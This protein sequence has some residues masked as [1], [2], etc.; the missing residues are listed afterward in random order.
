MMEVSTGRLDKILKYFNE[1]LYIGE[2]D[3]AIKSVD[4]QQ[5]LHGAVDQLAKD[6]GSD[7]FELHEKISVGNTVYVGPADLL[8][9]M[10]FNLLHNSVVHRGTHLAKVDIWVEI[11]VK[12]HHVHIMVK[13]N[14]QGIPQ[15]MQNFVFN[16]FVKGTGQTQGAGLGLYFVKNLVSQLNGEVTLESQMGEGVQV[17]ITLPLDPQSETT[18]I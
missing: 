14:G 8:R 7:A 10:L 5:V 15:D 18:A 4:F 13:D 11:K 16:M 2:Y 3:R 6:V 17:V 9:T 12:G 1:I